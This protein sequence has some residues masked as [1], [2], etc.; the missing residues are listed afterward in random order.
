MLHGNAGPNGDLISQGKE[1]APLMVT[2][3]AAEA[4]SSFGSPGTA[5]HPRKLTFG[6]AQ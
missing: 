6:K 5:R 2:I 3:S 1:G 4:T